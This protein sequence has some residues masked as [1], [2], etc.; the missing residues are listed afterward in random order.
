MVV[1]KF[2][3]E[4]GTFTIRLTIPVYEKRKYIGYIY[5]GDVETLNYEWRY[6]YDG[7]EFIGG[8][9]GMTELSTC[10]SAVSSSEIKGKVTVDK[11]IEKFKEKLAKYGGSIST[12]VSDTCSRNLGLDVWLINSLII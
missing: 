8:D 7:V 4:K 12:V 1:E 11:V 2:S 9:F 10:F 3:E 5:N 6:L